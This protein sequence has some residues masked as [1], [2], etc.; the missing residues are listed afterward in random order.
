M[1]PRVYQS[2]WL[3]AQRPLNSRLFLWEK[4]FNVNPRVSKCSEISFLGT[5][6]RL[7]GDLAKIRHVITY[8]ISPFEQRAFPN[9]FSKGI[10][11]IWRHS[12]NIYIQGCTTHG[13]Y[14]P[15]PHMGQ[16]CSWTDQKK[17]NYDN[18]SLCNFLFL[19]NKSKYLCEKWISDLLPINHFDSVYLFN[20][21][22]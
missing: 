12:K 5:M 9:Y 21:V 2:W 8:S 6:G 13:S 16:S 4:Q 18:A 7:L 22:P 19:F 3:K 14:V 10:P 11:N 15:D 1:K 17:A 20:K